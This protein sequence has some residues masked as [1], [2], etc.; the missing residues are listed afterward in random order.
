M[1]YMIINDIISIEIFK[2]LYNVDLIELEIEVV[3]HCC[4]KFPQ[5]LS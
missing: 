1:R 4:V 5:F 2:N 3:L